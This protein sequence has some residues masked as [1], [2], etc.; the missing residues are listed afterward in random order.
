[1][2]QELTTDTSDTT[3]LR[4]APEG[5]HTGARHVAPY[6][7]NLIRNPG[8]ILTIPDNPRWGRVRSRYMFR[9]SLIA[10]AM[11]LLSLALIFLGDSR[12]TDAAGVSLI[13]PGGGFL[14]NGWPVLF[15]LTWACFW[16]GWNFW[17]GFGTTVHLGLTYL[18]SLVGGIALVD[19]PRLGMEEGTTWPWVVPTLLLAA[20]AYVGS[21]LLRTVRG[22]AR[23]EAMKSERTDYLT[24]L[25]PQVVA[26]VVRSFDPPEMRPEVQSFDPVAITPGND[27]QPPLPVTDGDAATVEYLLKIAMQPVSSFE[28]WDWGKN[29]VEASALRYQVTEVGC[30]LATLQ[31]NYLPAYPSLL[32]QAQ[33]NVVAKAQEIPVWGYW[34]F[35]L[36]F[37]SL[38]RNPDPI[39]GAGYQNIMFGGFLTRHLAHYEAATHDHRYDEPNALNF[40]WDDN[41]TYSYS[42]PEIVAHNS[43]AFEHAPLGMWPCEP[44]QVYPV[45]NQMGAVGTQGFGAMHGSDEWSRVEDRYL[46]ALDV[47]WMKLNGD[48]YGHFNERLGL[49]VGGLTWNDETSPAFMDANQHLY[50]LGRTTSPEVAA[51]MY[52][53][54]KNAET[55]ARLPIVDGALA[56][57]RPEAV[58]RRGLKRLLTLFPSFKHYLSGAWVDMSLSGWPTSDVVMYAAIGNMARLFGDDEV[59]DAAIRGLDKQHLSKQHDGRPYPAVLSAITMAARAR[60]ARLYKQDDFLTARV[61]RYEGPLL[62]SAPYPEV[63]VTYANGRD[64]RLV[65]TLEP[66]REA[67]SYRLTFERLLPDTEY[68]VGR[69]GVTFRTDQHGAGEASVPLVER[70]TWL[71]EPASTANTDRERSPE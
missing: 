17:V 54:G 52:L 65:L 5:S 48:T 63:L 66:T 21:H 38:K 50:M 28:G 59:A 46:K 34:Y 61:P 8:H 49:N 39:V 10:L 19:G 4:I 37:G 47:E 71:I 53:L 15:V 35:E 36:F 13:V 64:G 57:P 9:T 51:R 11:S 16:L 18:V 58:E 40:T 62:A 68:A 70:Q 1:M 27:P 12:W 67:G 31:A 7:G 56:L 60:W 26:S 3:P 20:A 24:G 69:T 6:S 29:A 45:C 23:D 32:E 30:T 22:R 55:L 41:R 14:Y 33:Q 43:A 2:T 25:D 42:Y 44:G